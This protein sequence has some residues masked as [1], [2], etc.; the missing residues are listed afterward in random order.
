MELTSRLVR[1]LI[2]IITINILFKSS[3]VDAKKSHK[4]K[5]SSWKNLAVPPA[6]LSFIGPPRTG[7][8]F[9]KRTKP[10][11]TTT[12]IKITSTKALSFKLGS[13]ETEHN[14]ENTLDNI[15]PGQNPFSD[16][17]SN[18]ENDGIDIVNDGNSTIKN[19]NGTAN[20]ILEVI[21][22]APYFHGRSKYSKK[23]VLIVSFYALLALCCIIMAVFLIR[24]IQ[25][26]NKRHRQYMLLTKRDLE[27]P[28][29]GG[30]I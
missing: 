4:K 12:T 10:T 17:P 21:N 8:T 19:N 14:L 16:L 27:F 18:L 15:S 22:I 11:V 13:N 25:N 23:F 2:L 28:L 24:G 3:R 7:S 6:N 20:T 30:G 1:V 29:G 26:R 5:N 9:N